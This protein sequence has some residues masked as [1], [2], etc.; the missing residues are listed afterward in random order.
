MST[1][2]LMTRSC[3]EL[4]IT[5]CNSANGVYYCYCSGRLCN[6]PENDKQPPPPPPP[7]AGEGEGGREPPLDDED[8]LSGEGSGVGGAAEETSPTTTRTP[9]TRTPPTSTPGQHKRTTSEAAHLKY[10]LAII[11]AALFIQLLF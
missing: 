1:D 5:T 11:P 7:V 8:A 10:H 4:N 9:T 2:G 6:G 3:G